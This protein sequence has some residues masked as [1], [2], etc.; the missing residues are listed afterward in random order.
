MFG[1]T[2]DTHFGLQTLAG[3]LFSTEP[4]GWAVISDVI[5]KAGSG[6]FPIFLE[7]PLWAQ[8]GSESVVGG[9]FA[10]LTMY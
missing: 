10:Q 4:E 3:H 1:T 5:D 2:S 7:L 6:L 8:C 9:V